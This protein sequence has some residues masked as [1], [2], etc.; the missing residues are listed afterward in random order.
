MAFANCDVFPLV[1]IHYTM[2]VLI[3]IVL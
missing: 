1:N 3:F 2:H